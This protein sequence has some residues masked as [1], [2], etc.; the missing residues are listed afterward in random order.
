MIR[1]LTILCTLFAALS[2]LLI[3]CGGRSE[4]GTLV[5]EVGGLPDGIS[6]SVA[7][8]FL[9][10]DNFKYINDTY[11][12]A[13]GDSLIRAVAARVSAELRETD[14]LALWGGDEFVLLFPGL[15]TT[16]EVDRK[17]VV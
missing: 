1:R 4:G 9:D 2:G 13:F 15:D 11:S 8:M 7:V 12:H 3:A 14:T 6:A 10:L 5:V 16:T 17:S